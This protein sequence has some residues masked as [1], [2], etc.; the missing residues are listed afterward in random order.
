MD[1]RF[2]VR[3]TIS[4]LFCTALQRATPLGVARTPSL[5]LQPSATEDN[6]TEFPE[7]YPQHTFNC[8]CRVHDSPDG[9]CD[10]TSELILLTVDMSEEL[11]VQMEVRRWN[12]FNAGSETAPMTDNGNGTWSYPCGGRRTLLSVLSMGSRVVTSLVLNV[13]CCV[14]QWKPETHHR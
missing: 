12:F 6:D 2:P 4:M 13:L 14:T 11:V 7:D 8:T 9:V 3:I 10:P 1:G 5:Q